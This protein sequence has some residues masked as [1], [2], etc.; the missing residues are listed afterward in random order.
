M[1]SPTIPLLILEPVKINLKFAPEANEKPAYLLRNKHAQRINQILSCPNLAVQ[2]RNQTNQVKFEGQ[3]EDSPYSPRPHKSA[4]R[5]LKKKKKKGKGKKDQA[6]TSAINRSFSF[7][8]PILMP[9]D[10]GTSQ[11]S[12]RKQSPT[13]P[14][15]NQA[16]HLSATFSFRSPTHYSPAN[17]PHHT[18]T[19]LYLP[20]G[21]QTN[22]HITAV[23]PCSLSHYRSRC[24]EKGR[25][26]RE[27]VQWLSRS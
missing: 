7:S 23:F 20:T 5:P 25:E 27:S 22:E 18:T 1:L 13:Y 16:T 2:S 24:R 21:K 3:T 17:A 6:Y 15:V 8:L 26:R 10:P 4:S 19:A 11:S 12:T 9:L 14:L